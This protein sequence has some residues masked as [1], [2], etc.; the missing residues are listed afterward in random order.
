M[1]TPTSSGGRTPVAMADMPTKPTT[2][3][4]PVTQKEKQA[5]R[6]SLNTDL[7]D[8]AKK[9]NKSTKANVK[10]NIRERMQQPMKKFPLYN[11]ENN[12]T[13]DELSAVMEGE[14]DQNNSNS[15]SHVRPASLYK[16][17]A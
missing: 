16:N 15:Y 10:Q 17:S 6:Q 13:P 4:N 11:A 1:I 2:K 9:R 5:M 14:R 3:N 8:I 7:Q 12:T